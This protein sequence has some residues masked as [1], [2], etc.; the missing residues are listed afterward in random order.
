MREDIEERLYEKGRALLEA[1]Y[2]FWKDCHENGQT[3]AIRWLEDDK[4]HILIFTR[5]EYKSQL[6]ENIWNQ[7]DKDKTI[8][9]SQ[10]ILVDDEEE[11]E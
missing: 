5:G 7:I 3:G 10:R 9:F 1:A 4:G 6:M 8:R 11:N 2:D